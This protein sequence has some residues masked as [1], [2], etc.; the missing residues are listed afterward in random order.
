MKK[1]KSIEL[2]QGLKLTIKR[3]EN[4]DLFIGFKKDNLI[5][6]DF[7]W[8]VP[9][10][11]KFRLSRKNDWSAVMP[12]HHGQKP[13]VLVGRFDEIKDLFNL[14][15]EIGHV[16]DSTETEFIW[17][18][19]KANQKSRALDKANIYPESR[20]KAIKKEYEEVLLAERSAW[21][22]AIRQAH[23]LELQYGFDLFKKNFS[24]TDAIV[25]YVNQYLKTYEQNY[26]GELRD[27]DIYSKEEMIELFS[28]LGQSEPE[29]AN[30]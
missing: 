28:R 10:G 7:N 2:G 5:V 24:R 15:H 3:K 4:D 30:G 19:I 12:N 8:F 26:L 23:L 13:E 11:T 18:A 27:F 20:L 21:L 16:V 29:E 1:E 6:L 14:L 9:A 22:F 17:S 25:D